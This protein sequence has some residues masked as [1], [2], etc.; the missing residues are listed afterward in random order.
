MTET[1]VHGTGNKM[2]YMAIDDAGG[3]VDV[4]GN[5]GDRDNSGSASLSIGENRGRIVRIQRTMEK[6]VR[7]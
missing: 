4:F 7:S 1:T 6:S 3:R 2:A 5:G